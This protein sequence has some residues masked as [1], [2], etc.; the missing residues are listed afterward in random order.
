MINTIIN[1]INYVEMNIS[2]QHKDCHSDSSYKIFHQ[3]HKIKLS[4]KTQ[5]AV[6]ESVT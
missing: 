6:K 5:L 4:W 1:L 2:S 3:K